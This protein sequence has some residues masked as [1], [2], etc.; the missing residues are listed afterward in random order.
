MDLPEVITR[1]S[2]MT[3]Y[4]PIRKG[5]GYM[6]IC[7]AHDDLQPSLSIFKSNKTGKIFF[8]CFRGCDYKAIKDI[9]NIGD[10]TENKGKVKYTDKPFWELPIVKTYDYVNAAGKLVY[11]KVR[12]EPKAFSLRYRKGKKW[13]GGRNGHEPILYNLPNV[14]NSKIVFV[15]EGEKDTDVLIEW[16][17]AGTC[18]YDGAGKWLSSYNKYLW[19]KTVYIIPHNDEAGL[20]HGELVRNSV[21]KIARVKIIRLPGLSY[22]QDLFDWREMG[23]TLENLYQ[24]LPE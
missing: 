20:A 16:G 6:A 11:Q 5:Y 23:F 15:A 12:Y 24:L 19:G 14:I 7:P 8:N 3:G 13:A 17:L 21:A 4:T 18:N 9:I 22:K 10:E 1:L 2:Y